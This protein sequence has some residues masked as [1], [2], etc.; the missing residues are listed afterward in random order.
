[1]IVLQ[2]RKARA[3]NEHKE[4]IQ[5]LWCVG[6]GIMFRKHLIKYFTLCGQQKKSVETALRDLIDSDLI[7]V[8]RYGNSHVLK[9][10]KY[11]IYTL[12]GKKSSEVDSVR[13]SNK[14]ILRSAFLNERI[15]NDLA[16]DPNHLHLEKGFAHNLRRIQ[17][18]R[19]HASFEK[20]S[21]EILNYLWGLDRRNE[22]RGINKKF[23][24]I[25]VKNEIK[26]LIVV[27]E[28]TEK[29]KF[30]QEARTLRIKK[31]SNPG[32]EINLNGMHSRDIYFSFSAIG[33]QYFLNL[34]LLDLQ[35][36]MTEKQLETKLKLA[37]PYM[38]YL[39]DPA[40]QIRINVLVASRVR[41]DYFESRMNRIATNVSRATKI[42]NVEMRTINLNLEETL[43]ARMT[44][45]N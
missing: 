16:F 43:F 18:L 30:K 12:L 41:H 6:K 7:E 5:C 22:D 21:Y 36:N 29:G 20:R 42:H 3:F 4:F 23:L 15:L 33:E 26:D 9:L 10:K 8:F 17:Y 27:R 32:Y 38:K 35:S 28:Y 31:E 39:I 37:I 13:Y 45:I 40:V 24:A 19:S 14:K 25:S 2:K 11:G 34:D 44:I 1:M